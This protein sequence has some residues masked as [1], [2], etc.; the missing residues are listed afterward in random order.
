MVGPPISYNDKIKCRKLTAFF[1]EDGEE[2][3]KEKTKD[4]IKRI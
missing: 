2:V 3:K 1:N 4:D